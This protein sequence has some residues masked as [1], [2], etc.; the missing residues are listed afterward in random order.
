MKLTCVVVA[1]F[2]VAGCV[3]ESREVESGLC[4]DHPE[5]YNAM[6]EYP[7]VKWAARKGTMPEV[8][9]MRDICTLADRDPS[10]AYRI[11]YAPWV[12]D[13]ISKDEEMLLRTIMEISEYDTALA[14][15]VV[16]CWWVVD[17]LQSEEVEAV[18]KV[19]EILLRDRA[20]AWTVVSSEWFKTYITTEELD[21]LHMVADAPLEYALG[22]SGEPWFSD[23]LTYEEVSLMRELETFYTYYPSLALEV[24]E[25][26]SSGVV[27]QENTSQIQKVNT[28]IREDAA[29][30]EALKI[31]PLTAESWSAWASLSA[32]GI[33]DRTV[34]Q[35]IRGRLTLPVQEAEV[36][37]LENLAAL[38][39]NDRQLVDYLERNDYLCEFTQEKGHFLR[40]LAVLSDSN[41][42]EDYEKA[43]KAA[44]FASQGL[45]YEDPVEEYRYDLLYQTLQVVDP[46][47]LKLYLPLLKVS[48][49][50]YGERFYGWRLHNTDVVVMSNDKYL[51][52]LELSAYVNLLQFFMEGDQRGLFPTDVTQFTEEELY[53]LMDVPYEYFV[54][55]DGTITSIESLSSPLMRGSEAILATARNILTLEERRETLQNQ[56]GDYS[57]REKYLE[58]RGFPL[59]KEIKEEGELTDQL[60][61]FVSGK[62]WE[63]PTEEACVCHTY[64]SIMDLKSMGIPATMMYW[65]SGE[66][67]HL[68]PAYRAGD[69]ILKKVRED[70]G[71]YKHPF[72]YG[73][74]ISPW[75]QAGY[76]DLKSRNILVVQIY[77][78][79]SRSFVSLWGR[80][81]T[82]V[83]DPLALVA[84]GLLVAGFI[85]VMI[86]I[87][88]DIFSMRLT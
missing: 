54:N 15:A 55:V 11:M 58:D 76:K 43:V 9:Y 59:L 75:D 19:H 69:T 32:I 33:Q 79:P 5:I 46:E 17:S 40:F 84:V 57:F 42:F 70:P 16:D 64:Q 27:T 6:K 66:S 2:L 44:Q 72:M 73:N 63:A 25:L 23:F 28:L 34:A 30:F 53:Y 13:F 41:P 61:V 8:G 38:F 24:I 1:I 62:N 68:Y 56:W 39:M 36:Y 31:E 7:W 10:I 50:I 14:R 45:V 82:L 52:N 12:G 83:E 86:K 51:S 3:D 18:Q 81:K 4:P 87:F 67:A 21:T 65:Y 85:F 71:K 35:S 49:T 78:V 60:F 47:T 26:E 88:R 29:L 22:I 20:L 37:C 74:F 48:L 80:P 77:D